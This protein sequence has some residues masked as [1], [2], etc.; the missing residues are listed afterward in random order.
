MNHELIKNGSG[1]LV[2]KIGS[3]ILI[4]DDGRARQSWM[5]GLV[6]QLARRPGPV[7][8]VSSGTIGLGREALGLD[9]RPGSLA[10]AQAAAAIGQIDLAHT[11]RT[12][13]AKSGRKAAQVLLT[14]GD[15]EDRKRYLNARDT[16]ETLLE[17]GIV[18]IVN[19]NDTVATGEIRFGDNDR[20]AARTAQ[21]VDAELLVLLSDVDGLYDADPRTC[22]AARRIPEVP[23]IDASIEELAGAAST[24]GFGTGGMVSK[25]SAARIATA[26][27]CPVLL[28]SG[29]GEGDPFEPVANDRAGTWFHAAE[30]PLVQRKQWLRGLQL[31]DGALHVDAGAVAA[32]EDGASLLA[33]GIIRHEGE[34]DRGAPIRIEGPAGLVGQGLSGYSSDEIE[35]I[36]GEHSDRIESILGY[37]G[38]GAVVH[39][40]DLVLYQLDESQ[41]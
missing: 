35:T 22:E 34:F 36:R 3:S 16:L 8:I 14:L 2:V 33:S 41:E 27:G 7:V 1:T 24:T 19:E 32:L 12:A 31:H 29:H 4:D 37:A 17:R 5:T 40:D 28:C 10:E 39:R 26:A 20:L 6:E 9:G 18:P 38:R 25:I 30:R 23:V 13:W 11:W 21:L 15:L